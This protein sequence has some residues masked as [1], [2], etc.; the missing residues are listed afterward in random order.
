[1]EVNGIPFATAGGIGLPAA[2]AARADRLRGGKGLGARIF[3]RLRRV[4]YII[5]AIMEI[6]GQ[7]RPVRGSFDI[8]SDTAPEFPTRPWA[9]VLI[10]NGPTTGG[11]CASPEADIRDGRLDLFTIEAPRR[12]L[13][14]GWVVLRTRLGCAAGCREVRST[15]R[16]SLTLVTPRPVPFFGDG[17]I[18]LRDRRFDIRVRPLALPLVTPVPLPSTRCCRG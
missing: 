6:A 12:R 14:L 13:R 10:S 7:W 3:R 4:V 15:R 8:T 2:I 5:A 9:V 11:F 17:E 1:M 18:L 16:R